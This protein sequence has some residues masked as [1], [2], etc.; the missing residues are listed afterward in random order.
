[1]LSHIYVFDIELGIQ[2]CYSVVLNKS[3]QLCVHG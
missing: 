2:L 1:M 3:Q